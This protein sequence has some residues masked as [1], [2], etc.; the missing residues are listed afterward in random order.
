MKTLPLLAATA[1]VGLAIVG[2]ANFTS[3][4]KPL[5]TV[6]DVD[7]ERYS[8]KWYEIARL[9]N[10][11]QKGCLR[12][13]AEYT[14]LPDGKIKVVNSCVKGDGEVETISGKAKVVPGS[15]DAKLKVSFFGPFYFGDY[16]IIG[17]DKEYKWAVVGTPSRKY[18]WFLART[19]EVGDA[20]FQTMVTIARQKGFDLANLLLSETQAGR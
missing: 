5:A 11:F 16:W 3:N 17:L 18:L 6:V 15:T 1:I 12:S 19:P 20:D 8:G 4:R 2:C 13:T 10:S 14:P 9:P 7:L